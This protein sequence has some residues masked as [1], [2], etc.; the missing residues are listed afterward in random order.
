MGGW[1]AVTIKSVFNAS[2]VSFRPA[3]KSQ[4]NELLLAALAATDYGIMLTDLDHTTLACNG[5]FGDI[6][7]VDPAKVVTSTAEE[8]RSMVAHRIS[9][10]DEW[11]QELTEAYS[12]HQKIKQTTL[13]LKNPHCIIRRYTAPVQDQSGKEVGRLW[14]FLDVTDQE[15][16]RHRSQLLQDA[17]LLAHPDPKYVYGKLVDALAEFYDSVS[18]LSI[19][20]ENYMEFRAVGAPEDHFVHGVPGN[21]LSDSFCQFCLASGPIIIQNAAH[22]SEMS[23]MLPVQLGFTRYAGTPL[24]SPQAEVIGTLCFMD[25]HS[26]QTLSDE[27]LGLLRLIAMRVSS[28]LERERQINSLE[29]DLAEAQDRAIQNEKLA[30]AGTLSATIAHDIR[31]ILTALNLDIDMAGANPGECLKLVT[32]HLSRFSLLAHRLLSYAKPHKVAQEPVLITECLERVLDLMAGHIQ[33]GQVS[34]KAYLPD[35]LPKIMADPARLDHLFV[36]LVLNAL[37]AMGSKGRL[38]VSTW[39]EEGKVIVTIQDTGPGMTEEEQSALFRPFASQRSD[40]FG[41]GLFSALQIAKECQGAISVKSQ[42]GAGST[43]RVEIPHL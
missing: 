35:G 5:R 30:V 27:D 40:G 2:K 18:L 16:R 32:G 41:L 21:N 4:E 29:L 10:L 37:Q 25:G 8:V 14:T 7:G 31:N 17:S 24:F 36:N 22:Q 34:L 39:A 28:E 11:N 9:D 12:D 43:F 33:I 3:Y 1:F 13:T 42:I 15:K 23:H 6:W 26:D 20:H 38:T 19:C